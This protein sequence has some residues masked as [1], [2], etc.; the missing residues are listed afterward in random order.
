MKIKDI[1]NRLRK[2]ADIIEENARI[3]PSAFIT[4][5]SMVNRYPSRNAAAMAL[6]TSQQQLKNLI[7]A[8]ALVDEH[9]Q[10]WI[11]SKTVLKEQ[12]K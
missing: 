8:G 11:K 7:E 2:L 1:V 6:G 12:G 5:Y 3:T 10:V 4:V 9:G